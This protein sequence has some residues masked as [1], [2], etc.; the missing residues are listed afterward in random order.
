MAVVDHSE[1]CLQLATLLTCAG[2]IM[3]AMN[4]KHVDA[5]VSVNIDMVTQAKSLKCCE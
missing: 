2:D 5:P 1:V 4:I 3:V